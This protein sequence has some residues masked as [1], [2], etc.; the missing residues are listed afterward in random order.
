[1]MVLLQP[2]LILSAISSWKL[3]PAIRPSEGMYTLSPA[4]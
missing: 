1:M 4:L 3:C 2:R